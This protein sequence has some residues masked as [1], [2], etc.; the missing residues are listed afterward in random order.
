MGINVNLVGRDLAEAHR[1]YSP[2]GRLERQRT[3]DRRAATGKWERSPL[4]MWKWIGDI[5]SRMTPSEQ[6]EDADMA[7]HE[8]GRLT[9]DTWC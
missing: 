5:Y 7:G 2:V 4:E 1:K 3:W 6:A 8:L 9:P